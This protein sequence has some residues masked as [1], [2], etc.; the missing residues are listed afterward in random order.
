[1]PFA[2]NPSGLAAVTLDGTKAYTFGEQGGSLIAI[3][4]A[5]GETVGTAK[6]EG[7]MPDGYLPARRDP[8][9]DLTPSCE[10]RGPAVATVGGKKVALA[11]FPVVEQGSGTQPDAEA[12]EMVA[13]DADSGRTAWRTRLDLQEEHTTCRVAG[14]SG[15]TAVLVL[16][17]DR[18]IGVSHTT[19][20]VDLTT[21]KVVWQQENFEAQLVLNH[22][23]V[24]GTENAEGWVVLASHDAERGARQWTSSATSYGQLDATMFSPERVL[25]RAVGLGSGTTVVK[26]SDGSPQ[27]LEGYGEDSPA[28]NRCLY[29]GRSLT[30]CS[31]GDE[32][33]AELVAY[34]AD[35]KRRWRIGGPSDDTGRIAPFLTAAYHGLVYG[36]V[37]RENRQP[38]P[39]VLDGRTG[40]DRERSPGAAPR[41]VNAYVGL[42][43]EGASVMVHRSAG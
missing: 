19:Y 39:I 36:V 21:R 3:D 29:D 33:E 13:L 7:S 34:D 10:K 35:G 9:R 43:D 4:L 17:G 30:V 27:P 32:E 20:G 1:M 16:G 15:H 23:V 38:E 31:M 12:V 37:Q 2:V 26:L 42:D 5:S 11:L 18:S 22:H 28:I 14:V 24:G 8:P 6:P 41:L 40:T 25:A